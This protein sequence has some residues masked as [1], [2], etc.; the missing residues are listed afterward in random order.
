MPAAVA[1][2]GPVA[3]STK[4][5]AFVAGGRTMCAGTAIFQLI[6]S[7]KFFNHESGLQ[8][9]LQSAISNQQSAIGN[10][11]SAIGNRQSAIVNPIFNRHSN[12]QSPIVNPSIS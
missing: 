6:F 2:R 8:S 10:R 4:T 9:P 3:N 1:D 7:G 11:Q 12:R 5:P